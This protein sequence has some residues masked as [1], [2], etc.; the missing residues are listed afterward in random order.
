MTHLPDYVKKHAHHLTIRSK[1][2][3]RL[4]RSILQNC[5]KPL[6]DCLCGIALNSLAGNIPHPQSDKS[7]LKRHK[8]LIY[9]L[10]SKSVPTSKKRKLLTSQTGSGVISLLLGPLIGLLG[11]LFG[12]QK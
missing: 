6:I 3:P 5:D 9:E 11:G 1:C 12:G 2:K 10:T 8:R 7:K 4:R